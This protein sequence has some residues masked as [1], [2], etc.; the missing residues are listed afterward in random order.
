MIT[1]GK[2]AL[3]RVLNED[4]WFLSL[5]GKRFETDKGAFKTQED[6]VNYVKTK[7]A[8]YA[9]KPTKIY[10]IFG[11]VYYHRLA[12]Y[13]N[14]LIGEVN[15]DISDFYGDEDVFICS[16]EAEKAFDDAVKAIA[17]KWQKDY[18]VMPTFIGFCEE[19]KQTI[20]LNPTE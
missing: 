13:M 10:L 6:A 15:W 4:G 8:D 7:I 1:K 2:R 3:N 16:R 18:N 19:T 20:T 11:K 12:D 17:D 9:E 14:Y 5:D